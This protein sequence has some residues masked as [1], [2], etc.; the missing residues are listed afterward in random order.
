MDPDVWAGAGDGFHRLEY[1]HGSRTKL[2][3]L[4]CATPRYPDFQLLETGDM[5][6]LTGTAPQGRETIRRSSSSSS[7]PHAAL[8]LFPTLSMTQRSQAM[9]YVPIRGA[10]VRMLNA[11]CEMAELDVIRCNRKEVGGWGFAPRLRGWRL[12][13]CTYK[14]SSR[15]PLTA[16][17]L[18]IFYTRRRREGPPC[19]L[20]IAAGSRRGCEFVVY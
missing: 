9:Q 19:I 12:A 17:R 14:I 20:E 18:A 3:S 10:E 16:D 7:S 8:S 13:S 11:R 15:P 6:D 1:K 5:N 4:K 2:G